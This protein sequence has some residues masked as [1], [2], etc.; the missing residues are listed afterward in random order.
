MPLPPRFMIRAA[1]AA[2]RSLMTLADLTVPAS[3][4]VFDASIGTERSFVLGAVAELGI[5]DLLAE[6]PADAKTLASRLEADPDVLHR[7]LR[8]AAAMRVVS[9]LPDGRFRETRLTKA[10]RSDASVSMRQ[11]VPLLHPAVDGGRLAGPGRQ[12]PDRAQRLPPGA[13]PVGLGLLRRPPG[14]GADL[15]RG[16]AGHDDLRCAGGRDRLSVA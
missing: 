16:D 3:I 12:R 5:A 2:R 8:A 9:L 7:L 14:R 15:R 6:G 10:L 4:A 1:L 11:M 13:R